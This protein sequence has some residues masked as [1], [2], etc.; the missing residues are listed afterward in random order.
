LEDE[1]VFGR[2]EIQALVTRCIS[3]HYNSSFYSCQNKLLYTKI[4]ESSKQNLTTDC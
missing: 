4:V 1:K 3:I 2:S